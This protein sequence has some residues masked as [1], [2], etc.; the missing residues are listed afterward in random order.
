MTFS[1]GRH[2]T[3]IVNI[4]F[5]TSIFHRIGKKNKQSSVSDAD[6]EIPTLGSTDNAGNLVNHSFTLGLGF[7]CLHR[8]PMIDSICK[9]LSASPSD[10]TL[11]KR[12]LLSK[13]KKK[14]KRICSK[15]SV[16]HQCES[17]FVDQYQT[18]GRIVS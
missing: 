7:L 2:T 11:P 17:H 4:L 10:K 8:R 9:F 3:L 13:K 16:E 18:V 1:V 5:K 12:G 15:S 6:R 14:K